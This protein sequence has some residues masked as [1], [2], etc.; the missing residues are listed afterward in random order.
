[1]PSNWFS[2]WSSDEKSGSLR[3]TGKF[4]EGLQVGKESQWRFKI[5]D[6]FRLNDETVA[7]IKDM[8]LRKTGTELG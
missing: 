2:F 7:G 5:L 6:S 4:L 3:E 8:S 1:M